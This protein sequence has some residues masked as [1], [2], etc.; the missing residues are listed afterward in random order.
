MLGRRAKA[1]KT[2]RR[3]PDRKGLAVHFGHENWNL[4]LSMMIGIRMSCGRS[5]HEIGRELQPVDF[6]IKEKF[7]IIP[8]IANVF[9]YAFSETDKLCARFVDYAPM[10]FQKIRTNFGIQHSDYINSAGPEQLLGN[11]L[12]GNLSSLSELSSEGKSGAF[13]YHTA[14]GRYLMKTITPKEH[15]LLRSM[16]TRYY[17]YIMQNPGTL[18]VRFL[19]LHCLKVPTRQGKRPEKHYFVVMNNVFNTPFEIHRRYD[20]KGSWVGRVTPLEQH[21]DPTV[22]LKDMDFQ[23]ANERIAVGSERASRLLTQLERDTAF[24]RENGIID[25]S[26]LLG[27]HK[28]GGSAEGYKP[29][30]GLS[31]NCSAAAAAAGAGA[32]PAARF[33]SDNSVTEGGAA[34]AD[35]PEACHQLGD[36]GG[37]LS[38]DRRFVYCFGIIDIL[39][40]Y[41]SK[42]RVE[43]HV[44]SLVSD[45]RG[46]SCVEPGLYAERFLGFMRGALV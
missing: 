26:L 12:L 10:V 32:A 27:V 25:Y 23:A 17:D 16:L 39:T 11:M 37:L 45:R 1:V 35:H 31:A 43:H 36:A 4:V 44:R 9:E 29:A 46:I 15:H 7:S 13:F 18:I 22:A 14:D 21:G 5:L 42:K 34:D 38:S 20:L 2:R 19:G 30:S 33:P 41:D 40:T 28:V 8:R 3:S 24:L 6:I